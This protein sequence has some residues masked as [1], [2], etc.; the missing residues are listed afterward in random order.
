MQIPLGGDDGGGGDGSG[1]EGGAVRVA[2][3][4]L[5]RMLAR[6]LFPV[7]SQAGQSVDAVDAGDA[8][9][10]RGVEM[11]HGVDLLLQTLTTILCLEPLLER[12]KA[13]QQRDVIDV[14][15]AEMVYE[16]LLKVAGSAEIA[17]RMLESSMY[18]ECTRA[19]V[20]PLPPPLPSPPP[21]LSALFGDSG[22]DFAVRGGD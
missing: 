4:E 7:G 16:Q 8:G 20:S 13:L 12:L 22:A 15:G 6:V 21:S 11:E 14:E 2:N 10:G 3:P 5:E 9:S 17:D 19:C 18:S 1:G